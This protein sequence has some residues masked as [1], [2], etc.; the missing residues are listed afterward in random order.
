MGFA[1]KC[2]EVVQKPLDGT[3]AKLLYRCLHQGRVYSCELLARSSLS[4][5][6]GHL[7]LDVLFF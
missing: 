5:A 6:P 4:I 2:V 1:S 7:Y 3:K